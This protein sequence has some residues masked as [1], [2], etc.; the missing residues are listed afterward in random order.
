MNVGSDMNHEIAK[1]FDE[2]GI[3][4][5]FQQRDIWLRN[6]EALTGAS[7]GDAQSDAAGDRN[8]TREDGAEKVAAQ[9]PTKAQEAQRMDDADGAGGA[10][11]DGR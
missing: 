1:R 8:Q 9:G 5:P 3:V 2:E 7:K 10:G 6:P 11:G 4:I